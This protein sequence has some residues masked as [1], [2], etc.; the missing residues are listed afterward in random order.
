MFDLRLQPKLH[1]SLL[2]FLLLLLTACNNTPTSPSNITE[3]TPVKTTETAAQEANNIQNQ[4][5]L[6]TQYAANNSLRFENITVD[7]GL[8]QN[9]AYSIIQ[10]SKGFMW[11][12]TQDGLDKYDGNSF[13]VYK[14]DPENPA[15]IS[16]N[17]ILTILE[18]HQGTL[19][20]GTLS[21]GLNS[22]DRELDQFAAYQHDPED[23]ASLSN[24]EVLTLYE[25]SSG[26]LWVGTRNGLNKLDRQNETFTHHQFNPDDTQSLSGDAVLSIYE[27]KA[28]DLWLGTD[29]GLNLFDP[30]TETFTRFQYDPNAPESISN[31]A[32]YS[33]YEDQAGGFWV[34]TDGGLNKFDHQSERFAH[35]QTDPD[36]PHSLSD[37]GVRMIYEDHS[38]DLWVATYGGGLNR[39]DRDREQFTRYQPNL[40]D[41]H[42]LSHQAVLALHQD[43]EGVLWIGTEGGGLNKLY[44]AGL[45][46]ANFKTNPNNPNSLSNS[47]VRGIHED[48]AGHLWVATNDG[49]NRFDPETGE[50][51]RYMHDPDDPLSLSSNII[52]DVYEDQSGRLWIGT[53]DA[54]LNLKEPDQ[55]G[56]IHYQADPDDSTSLSDNFVTTVYEDRGGVL[57]IGTFDGGLNQYDEESDHFTNYQADPDDPNSLPS[58]T[59]FSLY[60]DRQ[61]A[62]W[63]GL[64]GKGLAEFDRENGRF[65]HYPVDAQNENSL[66]NNLVTSF[67]E[68]ADG[69]LWIGTAGGLNKLDQ[70]RENFTHYREKDGLPNDTILGILDDQQGNLW[71]STNNG[72]SKF[73][74]ETETFVNYD[75]SDGLQSQEFSGWAYHQNN[76]GLMFFGGI[77]GLNVFSPADFPENVAIPPIVL[78]SLMQ[79]G[80]V[81]ETAVSKEDID[82][83]IL[84]WPANFFEFEFAALSYANPDENQYAYMLEGFDEDW[85]RVGN[86]SYGRYTN[87]P[88]GTY[89][90][91][92]IGSNNDGVWNEN[93]RSL[94]VTVVPPIWQTWWFF[95]VIFLLFIGI[96]FVG[97]RLRIR[98]VETRSYELETLVT[99][100][101]AKLSQT[102]TLLEQEIV[103]RQQAEAELAQRAAADA[104]IEERNRL[105]RE[106]HDSVTQSLHGSTLMAEAGQRLAAAGDLERAKGYLTR[107]GEISQQ[108]LKEMRLLVYELRPLALAEVSL[109]EALQQRLDAVERRAGVDVQ[110]L[111]DDD[112]DLPDAIEEALYRIAQEALNNAL[113]HSS[114]TLVE[115]VIHVTGIPP[116]K[117]V[118]LE[119]S[120]N[121]IGFD[122]NT[123]DGQGG[124][125][126][127]SMKERA[128]NLGGNLVVHSSPGEGTQVKATIDFLSST[129][130]ESKEGTE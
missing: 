78:T 65:T 51:H 47:D 67:F 119:V 106:L 101:T 57:W 91:R 107:L 103:E 6:P 1:E 117:H 110:L 104:V 71:L 70:Q 75:E 25:D 122:I 94:Q 18:D 123:L 56:F 13:T 128:E 68:D 29:N 9:G 64:I 59:V 79:G 126:L 121:G 105:A 20:I 109:T 100:R 37:N 127:A 5:S 30:I 8:S 54:G 50:W 4:S 62:F 124:I 34:G 82:E 83:I 21:G 28:G 15:S 113:K 98:S 22:Y 48:Q 17:W 27:T 99:E 66:S 36:D 85:V 10:N 77:N 11:F 49:L 112:I 125:G 23:N 69:A 24:N 26:T 130:D 32:V 84:N 43:Q 80:D 102:N 73:N 81:I 12:G 45:N 61:G 39:F 96:L 116:E 89:T 31:N 111:V 53:F 95:A 108:A 97:V 60:E 129:T 115:V 55:E 41:P 3:P 40:T 86:R 74:P 76:N 120:D 35:Y 33:I 88:G 14:H 114:P 46:F 2:I 16:D 42:S 38:D 87:L 90:L 63:V 92:L 93:G 44:L 72:L 118:T 19:W 58:N 7:D 52:G